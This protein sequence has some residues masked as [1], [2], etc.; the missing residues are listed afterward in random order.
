MILKQHTVKRTALLLALLLALSLAACGG[1]DSAA[2]AGT[3]GAA[4]GTQA[5]QEGDA[6]QAAPAEDAPTANDGYEKFSRLAIGMTEDEVNAILGEPAKVDKAYYYYNIMVNGEELQI[7]VWINTVSGIVTYFNGDFYKD[8]V[9]AAFADAGTDL[10]KAGE[11]KAGEDD[12]G[13]LETYEE[14]AQAFGTPGYLITA[15]EDGT[16]R[17]LWADANEGHMCVTFRADGSIKSYQGFC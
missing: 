7:E 4:A 8:S 9:L 17:Y 6:P 12:T 13:T 5:P 1:K 10:S 15:D 16:T 11:L 2:P 14:C 3:D